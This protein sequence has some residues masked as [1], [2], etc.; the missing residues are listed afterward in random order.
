MAKFVAMISRVCLTMLALLLTPTAISAERANQVTLDQVN[1]AIP[2]LETFAQELVLREQVPGLSIAIIFQDRVVYLK[3]FGVREMGKGD[4][5]TEDT[6][7]Q[8]ASLSKPITTTIVA[9][10]VSDGMLTWDTRIS[11]IDPEFQLYEAYPTQQLTPRDLFTMRSGLPGSA[12]D[13]LED[14][15]YDRAEDPPS[16][17]F[18]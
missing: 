11:A 8:I 14:I 10:L 1:T 16:S 4:P 17:P 9:A 15:G 3:G 7:F 18:Y 13:E 5:V 6:V 12:G 2:L